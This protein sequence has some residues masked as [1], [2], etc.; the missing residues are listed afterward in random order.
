MTPDSPQPP[1]PIPPRT[2]RAGA[3][4]RQARISILVGTSLLAFGLLQAH[5]AGA[6]E[7]EA[8]PPD[9]LP[10]AARGALPADTYGDPHVQDLLERARAA[11][12]RGVDGLESYDGTIWERI[13]VNLSIARFRRERGLF[14][15]ERAA[16]F[17]WNADGNHLV[18]WEGARRDVPIAGLSSARDHPDDLDADPDSARGIAADLAR[19]LARG[20]SLPPPLT[21]DPGSDRIV[22]GVVGGGRSGEGWALHPLADTA[23][24][25]YRYRSGDTLRITLPERD[26]PVTLA[27]VRVEPRRAAFELLSASLWFELEEATLV[28]ATYRPS[29]PFNLEV[30]GPEDA[31]DVPR[32]LRPVEFEIRYVTVDHGF[33]DFRW[34]IPRRLAFEGELRAGAILRTPATYE[35]TVTG[36]MVNTERDGDAFPD[37]APPGWRLTEVVREEDE[38][39]N[40]LRTVTLFTPPASGLADHPAISAPGMGDASAFSPDEI[41]ELERG[42]RGLTPG[43]AFFAPTVAWGLQEGLTRYNRV[44]GFSSGAA[45]AVPVRADAR[46]RGEARIG[47]AD[48]D[49]GGEL[50]LSRGTPARGDQ[51]AVFRRL[52]SA[53]EWA[54]GHTLAASLGTVLWGS[55]RTPWY[56]STGAEVLVARD[57]RSSLRQVRFFAEAHRSAR[58]GTNVHLTRLIDGDSLKLNPPATRGH[59]FG[60]DARHRW[61]SG[62]SPERPRLFTHLRL[63]GGGGTTAYGRGW[64]GMGATAPLGAR[65]AVGLEGAAGTTV[66][67]PPDQRLFHPGGPQ[68][69]RG[70]SSGERRGDAFWLARGEVAGGPTGLRVSLFT[71]VLMVGPRDQVFRSGEP[72]QVVGLGFSGLDGLLRL[73]VSRGV[74]GPERWRF[75]AYLDGIL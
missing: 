28:R 35:W 24:Y 51:V 73:D 13:S 8:P 34:W 26:R 29:R 45:V 16:R 42:L 44:E 2:P 56:R 33:F 65:L 64:L 25:H 1:A 30:D 59:W 47:L 48:L 14:H 58:R 41:Q 50:R 62:V 23:G 22:F 39:G 55:E 37:E 52:S 6:Q 9:T 43:A 49:P 63:E 7:P 40:P 75:L 27:E 17:R 61:Q 46:F 54:P 4:L 57:G 67:E 69:F 72:E 5:T 12:N 20:T 71:D 66:G 3:A 60:L 31:D 36:L 68:G 32:I 21:F 18:R 11:R 19:S 15:Q 38:E 53:S 10:P 74:R 70:I